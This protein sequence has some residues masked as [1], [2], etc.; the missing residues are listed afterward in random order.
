MKLKER[1]IE[2]ER[3]RE[4]GNA[5]FSSIRVQMHVILNIELGG[6]IKQGRMRKHQK[7]TLKKATFCLK[8]AIFALLNGF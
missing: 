1:E 4:I 5:V 3:E 8:K 7:E 6:W 2:R